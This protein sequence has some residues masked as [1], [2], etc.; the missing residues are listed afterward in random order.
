MRL[1]EG[2]FDKSLKEA[3]KNYEEHSVSSDSREE[4]DDD[5]ESLGGQHTNTVLVKDDPL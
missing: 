3:L 4:E 5:E 1:H 2:A